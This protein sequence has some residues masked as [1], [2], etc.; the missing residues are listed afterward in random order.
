MQ[1]FGG[2]DLS[3][4]LT[5]AVVRALAHPAFVPAVPRCLPIEQSA[6]QLSPKMARRGD[7]ITTGNFSDW[8][9]VDYFS[10]WKWSRNALKAPV[11]IL[12]QM[13]PEE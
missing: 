10:P 4:A 7:E 9:D 8:A 1:E 13:Y 6:A 11:I 3:G 12:R 5:I 2:S